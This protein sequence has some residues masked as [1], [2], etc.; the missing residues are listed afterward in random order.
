MD[1]CGNYALHI[2]LLT[3]PLILDSISRTQGQVYYKHTTDE[4]SKVT[5]T[6]EGLGPTTIRVDKFPRNYQIT[7]H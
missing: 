6:S 3:E 5:I 7:T 1:K 4:V 2:K